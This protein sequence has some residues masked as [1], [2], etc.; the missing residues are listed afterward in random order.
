MSC[1]TRR[2]ALYQL[3]ASIRQAQASVMTPDVEDPGTANHSI[4]SF[5]IFVEDILLPHKN[6]SHLWSIF[7]QPCTGSTLYATLQKYLPRPRHQTPDTFL[8]N[9]LR[10]SVPLTTHIFI[11][12][13][14]HAAHGICSTHAIEKV[15]FM[16]KIRRLHVERHEPSTSWLCCKASHST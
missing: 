7:T 2:R 15:L 3:E 8:S 10:Y 11:V 14:L 1:S 12:V 9:A 5:I 4:H 16:T 13:Y 6:Q